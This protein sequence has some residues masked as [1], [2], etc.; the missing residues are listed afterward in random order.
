[1]SSNAAAATLSNPSFSSDQ[2]TAA[3]EQICRLL[4]QPDPT[5]SAQP[6]TYQRPIFVAVSASHL[7]HKRNVKT[8]E[9]HKR[10]KKAQGQRV[11]IKVQE[12]DHI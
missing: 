1:M 3:F 4:Q 2:I 12:V 6:I 7:K 9:Q 11:R 5:P 10:K 8:R